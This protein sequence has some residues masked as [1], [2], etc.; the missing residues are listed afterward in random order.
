RNSAGCRVWGLAAT[1]FRHCWADIRVVVCWLEV[2]VNDRASV[3]LRNWLAGVAAILGITGCGASEGNRYQEPPPQRVYVSQ[4]LQ[5]DVFDF[6]EETGTTEPFETVE[7]RARVEGFLEEIKFQ[8]GQD[9]IQA[10][11]ELFLIDQR[12]Y[13][14]V[15]TQAEAALR[16]AQAE[17]QDA[18]AKFR[19]SSVL[20]PQ[21]AI[22]Q[23]EL[24]ERAAALEVAKAKIVAAQANLDAARL[25][26]SYTIVKSPING[27]IGK[28]LVDRGN[29]VG[30]GMP[31]QLATVIRYDPIF[32]TFNISE[33]KLLDLKAANRSPRSAQGRSEREDVRIY[34]G[35]ANEEGYPHEGHLDFADLG[36][37]SSS[38]TFK[39]RAVFPNP[40]LRI[41]PGLFVRIRIPVGK[42]QGALLVPESAV[43]ADQEG[44]YVYVVNDRE[45]AKEVARRGITLGAKLGEMR[46][47]L[48]GLEPSD[49]F[50]VSGIQ[51]VRPGS[52]VAPEEVRLEAPPA[53]AGVSPAASM[54]EE[55]QAATPAPPADPPAA[56]TEDSAN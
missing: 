6:V 13:Q 41:V 49:V 36:V 38:G 29:L 17:A 10:G 48:S 31:T 14:A 53:A 26:L 27:R 3:S 47:A 46:V 11:D 54:S 20:A 16:V 52:K 24:F 28:A 43:G 15:V 2:L 7:V 50:V 5:Q 21:G 25:D 35:L 51:R 45:G 18:D 33:R 56:P 34:M 19:R 4:P 39:I 22:S 55:D 44:R 23:E 30:R 9:D 8:A 12:P 42:R 1:G 32:A 40:D 37:E